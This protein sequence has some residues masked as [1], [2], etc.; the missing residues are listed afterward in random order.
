[1]DDSSMTFRYLLQRGDDFMRSQ[2][3]PQSSFASPSL[4][5]FPPMVNLKVAN[6]VV[7]A[8]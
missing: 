5:G 6:D 1:M 3:A 4:S 8:E 7:T 2:I